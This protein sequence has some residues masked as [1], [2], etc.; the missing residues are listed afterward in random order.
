MIRRLV[1]AL[2]SKSFEQL[3]RLISSTAGER[4]DSCIMQNCTMPAVF[5]RG[6]NGS[7]RGIASIRQTVW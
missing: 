3:L 1:F 7:A 2:T 6:E 4:R 5:E